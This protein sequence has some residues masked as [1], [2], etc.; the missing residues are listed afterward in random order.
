MV[1]TTNRP[2]RKQYSDILENAAMS[3][4][5]TIGLILLSGMIASCARNGQWWRTDRLIL[6]APNNFSFVFINKLTFCAEG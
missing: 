2:V 4:V 6:S 1:L 5:K 3:F